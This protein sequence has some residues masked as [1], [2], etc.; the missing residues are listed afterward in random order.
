M[1][2]RR[3][4]LLTVL[5][6]LAVFAVALALFGAVNG[7]ESS[8]Q[9]GDGR[10]AAAAG[11][12]TD[13]RL[14]AHER[15]IRDGATSSK[16]YAA[17]GNL[18]LQKARETGDPSFGTRAERAFRTSL[19]SDPR[20]V[21]AVVGVGTVALARHDFRAGLEYGKRARRLAPSLVL[22]FGV[23]ADAQIELGR[24]EQAGR[25]LQ[26]M[27]DLKPNLASY[28]RVSY[29]RELHGDIPG[30]IEA[31]R[32]AASAGGAPEGTAY[33]QSLLGDLELNR[34]RGT[35]A[36]EAYRRALQQAPGHLPAT[37]GLARLDAGSG[38]LDASIRRL[39]QVVA[40][41]PLPE[42]TGLLGETE[43]AAG[44]RAEG[45]RH[46]ERAVLTERRV[47][48]APGGKADAGMVLLEADYGDRRRA[49]RMARRVW[50]AA[51]SV[52]AADALGWAL[53]RT[54]R[55]VAGV[56]WGM[57]ALRLGSRD[58]MFLFHAGMSAKAA[59]RPALARRLLAR[60]LRSNPS[61]SALH[62][63]RA[64]RA[65]RSLS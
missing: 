25:T 49:A 20:S 43:L 52:I 55:P 31:M 34:G 13:Q 32:L 29:F 30:A 28:S 14:R 7:S 51:P 44:R 62:A 63:P 36:R 24:Y 45:R 50:A 33:V 41:L 56:K 42:Y 16:S 64:R 8:S 17:F 10:E 46:V 3:P 40:R 38:R 26:R 15:A 47:L 27:V 58:P 19:R 37:V 53:T 18:L 2:L 6:P 12:S 65:L 39:R 59:G 23:L 61:F 1:T 60:A 35:A 48:A 11:G 21:D 22:P 5:V 54:G 57:R 4:H 9:P